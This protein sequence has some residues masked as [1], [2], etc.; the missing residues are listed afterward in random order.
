MHTPPPPP[1]PVSAHHLPGRQCLRLNSPSCLRHLAVF[2]TQLHPSQPP[3]ET[4]SAAS[5]VLCTLLPQHQL[6]ALPSPLCLC[7][8]CLCHQLC[9]PNS[10]THRHCWHPLEGP[11]GRPCVP[12]SLPLSLFPPAPCSWPAG[13]AA[14]CEGGW[15]GAEGSLQGPW[16]CQDVQAG[17]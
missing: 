14:R 16:S 11:L 9:S 5:A 15:S 17:P 2:V 7:F 8:S 13:R 12:R 10:S 1:P 3:A 6:P 4:P